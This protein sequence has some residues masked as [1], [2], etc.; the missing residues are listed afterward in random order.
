M[1]KAPTPSK[2][3]VVSSSLSADETVSVRRI[4]NGYIVSRQSYSG[5]T[6]YKSKETFVKVPPKISLK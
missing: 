3:K 2:G 1:A 4:E 5:K 6:G